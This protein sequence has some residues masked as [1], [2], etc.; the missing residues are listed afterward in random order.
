MS[1]RPWTAQE[2]LIVREMYPDHATKTVANRLGR[3][4]KSIYSAAHD[5]GLHKSAAYLAC[6]LS[7]RVQRGKQLP[8]LVK[9]QFLPGQVPWNKGIKGSTGLH[10]NS[11]A[12]HFASRAASESRNYV[13]IGSLRTT[14]DGYLEQKVT[15]DRSLSPARRWVALHRLVWEQAHGPVPAGRIVVFKPGTKTVQP[16]EL[17]ADRLECIS[18]AENALRNNPG[19]GNPQIQRLLQLK[20]CITRQVNKITRAA[21]AEKPTP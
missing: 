2:R 4:E 14:K 5:M 18:R 10:P 21:S 6:D 7:G 13:P 1:A 3:S 17:T 12:H 15:D 11:R 20:G 16:H 19:T 9:N 8:A